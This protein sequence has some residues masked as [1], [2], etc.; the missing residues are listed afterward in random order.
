MVYEIADAINTRYST[1]DL[2]LVI[3]SVFENLSSQDAMLEMTISNT[4]QPLK[5]FREHQVVSDSIAYV[6]VYT[7]SK[8]LV[9]KNSKQRGNEA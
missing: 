8:D 3:P 4:V 7:G 5:L 2:T 6:F 1:E 9:Y